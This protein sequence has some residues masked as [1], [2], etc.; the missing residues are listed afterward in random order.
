M[1]EISN[2]IQNL[3]KWREDQKK[4]LQQN[5]E[6]NRQ[7]KVN[8]QNRPQINDCAEYEKYLEKLN[9]IMTLYSESNKGRYKIF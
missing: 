8:I 9:G 2:K 3:Q 4:E 7:E 5:L 6:K 1:I